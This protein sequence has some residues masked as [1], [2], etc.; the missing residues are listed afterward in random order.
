[1]GKVET[2]SRSITMGHFRFRQPFREHCVA[3]PRG[4][5]RANYNADERCLITTHYSARKAMIGSV[6]TA[7][8]AGKILAPKAT[9]A[10]IEGTAIKVPRSCGLVS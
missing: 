6:W 9:K 7:R 2:R 5:K 3:S 4:W 8:Q 10:K 1:M